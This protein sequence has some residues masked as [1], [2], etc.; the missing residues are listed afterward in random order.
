LLE[1]LLDGD[2]G[3]RVIGGSS[4]RDSG[5]RR[6]STAM[7]ARLAPD[8]IITSTRLHGKEPGDVVADLKRSSP[9]STLILLTHRPDEPVPHPGADVSLPEDAVVRQLLPVIRKA[10]DRVRDRAPQTALARR[11]S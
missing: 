11:R 9:A 3:L 2:P 1:H 8:V 5:S 7:A 6:N 10:V 4:K